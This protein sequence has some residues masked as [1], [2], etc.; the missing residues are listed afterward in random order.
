MLLLTFALPVAADTNNVAKA[1]VSIIMPNTTVEYSPAG[2]YP[3]ADAGEYSPELRYEVTDS[4][5]GEKV[6]LPI[7]DIGV[8]TVRAYINSTSMHEAAQTVSTFT[9]TTATAYISVKKQSVAHTAMDNPVK[10][11][12]SPAWAAELL[13][14]S[15]SY[16]AIN[17]LSDKGS[18][19]EV[20]R[21]MGTYLV[22]MEAAPLSDKVTCPGKYLV[23]TIGE[24]SQPSV[25]DEES[26]LTVPPSFK[27]T[28]Q[29]L[30]VT[31]NGEEAVPQYSVNVAGA[32]SYLMYS[33]I[34]ADGKTGAYG[35]DPPV[36]PGDYIAS[37]FVLDTVIGSSRV[38]IDKMVADIKV[39]NKTFTYTPEG[40]YMPDI[41]TEPKGIELAY[42]AYKYVNGNTGEAVEFPLTECGTYLISVS[43][44]DIYRYS[45]VDSVNYFYITI[46]KQLPVIKGENVVA[47]EDGSFKSV[48]VNIEPSYA[49]Y[50]LQYYRVEGQSSVALAGAP[51]T[52]GEYYAVV[53]VKENQY[54]S[55]ATKVF[56][57]YIQSNVNENLVFA[58]KV[59]KA[60]CIIFVICG[61]ATAAFHIVWTKLQRR[62]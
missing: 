25:S 3:T 34:Y 44:A 20:P 52:A 23:Y 19:V 33:R 31:Y 51:V 36:E 24:K 40:V 41:Q 38:V 62:R 5:T 29:T 45:Y 16:Y 42:S 55:S 12:V 4:T 35:F 15:V 13:D 30:N 56:G 6:K 50:S 8:Y 17:S 11:S 54:V 47:V 26:L 28:V 22:K 27:A 53:S 58:G 7:V 10:Y 59:I 9:V 57:V 18:A 1:S 39:E 21:D 2:H 46:Q 32:E 14:I 49:D 48:N 61:V 43:P 60:L 37:C